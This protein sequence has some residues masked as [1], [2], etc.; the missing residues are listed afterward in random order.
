[1]LRRSTRE[2]KAL[3]RYSPSLHYL[4]LTDGGELESFDEAMEVS[5]KW[6]QAMDDDM[7]SLEKNDTWELTEVPAGKKALLNKF[8]VEPDGTIRF[9]AQLV[10]KGYSQRKG[11]YY[12]EIFSP[13]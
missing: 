8:K 4:L 5:I 1:M 3:E 10:F 13:L 7:W 6:E 12:T 11:I 9:K 2:I